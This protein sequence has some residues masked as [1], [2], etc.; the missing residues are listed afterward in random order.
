MYY[1]DGT[2][3][4]QLAATSTAE[5]TFPLIFSVR[6]EINNSGSLT[7]VVPDV[8]YSQ[9]APVPV[10]LSSGWNLISLPVQQAN[11][12]IASVLLTIQGAYEVVWA[13][14]NG[15][16]KVYDPNDTAGSTLKTMQAGIGYWIKTTAKNTLYVSGSTPSSSIQL[17]SGWNLVGYNGACTTPS[18]A[19][20]SVSSS[21]QVL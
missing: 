17:G 8:Q 19:L 15:A 13:Y 2:G 21:L 12:A 18:A 14:S 10:S 7:V 16:W 5:W 9:T 4:H 1:N 6:A 11:T 3:W 20:S